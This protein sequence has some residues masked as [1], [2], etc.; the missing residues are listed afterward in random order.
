MPGLKVHHTPTSKSAWDGPAN[1]TRLRA[2][3]TEAYYRKAFGWQDP[4]RDATTKVAY[5][6]IHHE[7]SGDGEIG[8]ANMRACVAGIAV[9]NGG[10]GGT[11]IPD[12]D[13]ARVHAHLAA[14]M[15]DADM[16]PPELKDSAAAETL[17]Y[18]LELKQI[19]EDGTFSGFL[20]VYDV[21]DAYGDIVERGAFAQTLKANGGSVP[22]L[23]QHD[24]RS[25]IGTL[26]LL[27]TDDALEAKGRLVLSVAKAREAYSLLKAN[28]VRGLSIGFRSVT[29]EYVGAKRKLKEIRLYEGSLVT[30]PANP[31]ALVNAVKSRD[32][33]LATMMD[34]LDEI[35]AVVI[36]LRA[37]VSVEQEKLFAQ[38][39]SSLE[40]WRKQLSG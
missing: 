7:V 36:E 30:F 10:R 31:L 16:E 24:V 12:S 9:L 23:W 33:T 4:E 1:E 3:E 18:G 27:D 38:S 19:E 40:N 35:H 8:A 21:V 22:L 20:S 25:P 11:T 13:R 29:E 32:D 15:M 39:I 26:E 2:G 34:R 28:V 5:K 37:G 14:H 17:D 6:F